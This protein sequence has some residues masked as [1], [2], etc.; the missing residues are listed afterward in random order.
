MSASNKV[1]HYS[2]DDGELLG[3]EIQREI[4]PEKDKLRELGL[5]L[6][7]MGIGTALIADLCE[8]AVMQVRKARYKTDDFSVQ[9]N[10]DAPALRPKSAF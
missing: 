5:S 1:E 10:D 6:P 7:Q 9:Y 4:N 3:F 2:E 8:M